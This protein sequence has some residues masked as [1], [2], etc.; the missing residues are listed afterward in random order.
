[1][2]SDSSDNIS[3]CLAAN[4]GI[5]TLSWQAS[6]FKAWFLQWLTSVYIGISIII[7]TPWFIINGKSLDYQQWLSLLTQP[8]INVSVL[9]FFYAIFFHAWVGMRDIIIDYIS[10]G[11][12]RLFILVMIALGLFVMS[13][14]ISVILLSVVRL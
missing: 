10:V 11:F 2:D 8:V 6:G 3:I 1:M 5:N 13:I 12:L 7:A 14:W 9:L 4:Q